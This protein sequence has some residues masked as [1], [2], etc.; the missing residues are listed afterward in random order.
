MLTFLSALDTVLLWGKAAFAG[1]SQSL[2]AWC[3]FS[4][5]RQP[6]TVHPNLTL[7]IY[8]LVATDRLL[9]RKLAAPIFTGE[10]TDAQ[11]GKNS[12]QFSERNQSGAVRARRKSASPAWFS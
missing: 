4:G 2:C 5:R 1:Q 7:L 9:G 3:L 12:V 11:M 6:D 8:P 10:E